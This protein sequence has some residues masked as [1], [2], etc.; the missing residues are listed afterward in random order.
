[1]DGHFVIEGWISKKD[2]NAQFGQL[3]SENTKHNPF[4]TSPLNNCA[5]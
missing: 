3:N 2:N 5:N 1:M 4:Y